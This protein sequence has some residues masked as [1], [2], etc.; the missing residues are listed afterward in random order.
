VLLIR[1][2]NVAG[3]VECDYEIVVAIN[4]EV[5][6]MG[7][8]TGHVREH[9]WPELLHHIAD[10]AA[11]RGQC[12]LTNAIKEGGDEVVNMEG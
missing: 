5:I 12:W 9:G 8:V 6:W 3:E 11:A 4:R 10:E 2:L 7:K 1:A